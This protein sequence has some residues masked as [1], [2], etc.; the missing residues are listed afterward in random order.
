M[1]STG[2]QLLPLN[3]ER[4]SETS[5]VLSSG[6]IRNMFTA[7]ANNEN[8]EKNCVTYQQTAWFMAKAVR[9]SDLFP[10]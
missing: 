7:C 5:F 10:R 6:K 8:N 2:Q 9:G 4:N 1:L 3:E